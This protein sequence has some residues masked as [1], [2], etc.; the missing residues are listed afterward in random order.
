M[1]DQL[2]KEAEFEDG[3]PSDIDAV[4]LDEIVDRVTES[5]A[6]DAKQQVQAVTAEY[7]AKVGELENQRQ[8]AVDRAERIERSAAQQPGV[9]S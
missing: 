7:E 6:A 1:S 5:Y 3:D 2:L 4:T 9:E 8:A